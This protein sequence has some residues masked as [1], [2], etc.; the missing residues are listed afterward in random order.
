MPAKVA[1]HG[2]ERGYKQELALGKTCPKCIAA[3]RVYNSQF[4]KAGRAKGLKYGSDQA[5]DHLASAPKRGV[6]GAASR[7]VTGHGP[8][9][10]SLAPTVAPA[11][12]QSNGEPSETGE[13]NSAREGVGARLT[14]ALGA[15]AGMRVP[16]QDPSQETYVEETEIPDYLHTVEEDPQPAGDW[17]ETDHSETIINAASMAKIE[18]NLGFYLSVLGMTVEMIDPYCGP[19]LYNNM[20]NIVKRWA[21]VIGHYPRAANLFLDDGA[22]VLFTWIGA[23][24]ATWPFLFAIY[25]HHLSKSVR[26]H[27]GVVERKIGENSYPV[28]GTTPPMYDFNTQGV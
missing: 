23:I 4:T 16:G 6:F 12:A 21:K 7:G 25:E 2:T 20:E 27:N 5:L 24:Q 28:D 8:Q 1:V 11:T 15:F 9:P 14:S 17:S 13:G 19:V 3:H 10:Q 22:G 26:V 18:E